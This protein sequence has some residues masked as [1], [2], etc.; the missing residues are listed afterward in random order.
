M[1]LTVVCILIAA[2]FGALADGGFVHPRFH[3]YRSFQREFTET[4]AFADMGITL[5]A[6]GICNT[7]SGKGTPYSDYPPVWL[8]E[9]QYDW[10]SCDRQFDDLIAASPEARFIVLVDLNSPIWLA[11]KLRFDSFV[12]ISHAA[13]MP[14]WRAAVKRY[15]GDFLAHVEARYGERTVAYVLL[16]GKTTEWFEEEQGVSSRVKNA[17][18]RAWC[19]K[20]GLKHGDCT[21]PETELSKAAFENVMY[22]PST[23]AAKIDYWRFHNSLVADAVLDFAHETRKAVGRQKEIGAFFGYYYICQKHLAAFCHLDYERVMASDDFDFV[24]SPATYT[25]R[26]CGRGT[27]SMTVP[28]TLRRYGK[29]LLHEIDYW[30]HDLALPW[31][32]KTRDYFHSREDDI[33]GNMRDATFAFVNGA[34]WWWFDQYGRFYATPGMHERIRRLAEIERAQDGRDYAS[35]AEVLLVA[36]P[37]SAYLMV[38]P[39]PKCPDGFVPANACGEDLRNRLNVL[40]FA[41][42]LASFNDL[43][44]MNLDRYRL[45][46]LP[47]TWEITPER[48][49]LLMKRVCTSGRT[50]VWTYAPGVS[51]GRTLDV[52]RVKQWTGAEFRAKDLSVTSMPGGWTSV[53]AYDHR[54]LDES[55]LKRLAKKAGVF[56]YS[57]RP[58]PIAANERFLAVHCKEGGRCEFRLPRRCGRVVDAFSGEVVGT[59]CDRF[60]VELASP[61]TRLFERFTS[62]NQT[63][64]TK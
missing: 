31:R 48:A 52:A 7:A 30:P 16:G 39:A 4:K 57:E 9:G 37:Q 25:E 59:N 26:E 29:R 3:A 23:E 56:F 15:L 5:R 61:D 24:I 28:G 35:E 33:A 58:M 40:G 53:Y 63:Q 11:R 19:A 21:P 2:S 36:D 51:D 38:D 44:V 50:V 18:W 55:T 13:A 62:N 41:Y 46:L 20:R 8:G 27:G 49:Q 6:V 64:T 10:A 32:T 1:R 60:S 45:I 14:Q 54:L 34:S 43:S 47:A 17:A 22:D 12:M 42:E